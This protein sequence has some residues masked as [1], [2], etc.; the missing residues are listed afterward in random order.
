MKDLGLEIRVLDFARGECGIG[1]F[2]CHCLAICVV[3]MLM[4]DH[5]NVCGAESTWVWVTTCSWEGLCNGYSI[6]DG[7]TDI[8]N[9]CLWQGKKS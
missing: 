6:S 1:L 3:L 2:D 8:D 7:D 9:R 5:G 4:R